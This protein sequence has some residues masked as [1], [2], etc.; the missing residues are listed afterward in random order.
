MLYFTHRSSPTGFFILLELN[1]AFCL[2]FRK[3][4]FKKKLKK[5]E[6]FNAREPGG[7]AG[8][9][10]GAANLDR[11]PG[12]QEVNYIFFFFLNNKG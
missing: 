3:P 12:C 4:R 10:L 7:N 5:E 6:F 9:L 1:N 8:G 11:G 2:P